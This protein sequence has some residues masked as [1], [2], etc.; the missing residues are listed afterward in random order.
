VRILS[1][2]GDFLE[3]NLSGIHTPYYYEAMFDVRVSSGGFTGAYSAHFDEGPIRDF[4]EQLKQLECTRR[5]QADI[6]SMSPGELKFAVGA[7]NEMGHIGIWGQMA[8]W[9]FDQFGKGFEQRLLFGFTFERPRLCHLI[10][11][12]EALLLPKVDPESWNT[13]WDEDKF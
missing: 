8:R 10:N 7:R 5:G 6:D 4:V 3:L 2:N 1:S 12:F 13:R 11:A 9:S